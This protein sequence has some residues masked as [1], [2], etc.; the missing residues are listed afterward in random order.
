M[1]KGKEGANFMA[2]D[3]GE[4][5]YNTEHLN[6]QNSFV[7]THGCDNLQ[8]MI[9]IVHKL[10]LPLFFESYE[11]LADMAAVPRSAKYLDLEDKDGN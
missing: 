11:K 7:E 10:K 5:I 3:L 2:K 1:N 6:P 9:A 8:T 4:I